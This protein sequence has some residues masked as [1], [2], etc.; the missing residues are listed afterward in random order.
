MLHHTILK[1]ALADVQVLKL[2]LL[3]RL[4]AVAV[5]CLHLIEGG[6]GVILHVSRLHKLLA[7]CTLMLLRLSVEN[8]VLITWFV[9]QLLLGIEWVHFM[10]L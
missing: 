10:R 6:L 3:R 9:G 2:G 4:R 7:L 5:G 1:V 8:Q